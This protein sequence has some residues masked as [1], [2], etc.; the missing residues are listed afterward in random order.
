M[1]EV[2]CGCYPALVDTGEVKV[3]DD[4]G[5]INIDTGYQIPG[6]FGKLLMIK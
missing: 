4:Q 5:C 1:A 6:G 3:A 2:F